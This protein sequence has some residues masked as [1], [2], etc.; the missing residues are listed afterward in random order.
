MGGW[1]GLGLSMVAFQIAAPFFFDRPSGGGI[2]WLQV[3][4]AGIV[5]AA[6]ATLGKEL[7]RFFSKPKS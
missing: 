1:V 3:M 5:G 4:C 7:A 6:G 2:N